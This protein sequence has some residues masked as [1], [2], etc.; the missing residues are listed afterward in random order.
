LLPASGKISARQNW[1]SY[2]N[3]VFRDVLPTPTAR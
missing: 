1:P 2:G 3:I